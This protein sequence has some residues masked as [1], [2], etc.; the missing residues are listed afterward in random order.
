MKKHLNDL[1]SKLSTAVYNCIRSQVKD[2]LKKQLIDGDL[3]SVDEIDNEELIEDIVWDEGFNRALLELVEHHKQGMES[4]VLDD[5]KHEIISSRERES[6]RKFYGTRQPEYCH[7][8][9]LN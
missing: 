4:G 1:Q 3:P 9:S 7:T 8:K 6:E 5:I 2:S